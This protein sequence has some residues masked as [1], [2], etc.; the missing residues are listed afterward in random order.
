ML[1]LLYLLW[2]KGNSNTLR[3][4]WHRIWILLMNLLL[5]PLLVISLKFLGVSTFSYVTP[6]DSVAIHLL[7]HEWITSLF[8]VTS[9]L[10]CHHAMTVILISPRLHIKNC[11][12]QIC[13]QTLQQH[14][15]LVLAVL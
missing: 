7:T 15:I 2:F 5:T 11:F 4:I 8:I 12:F 9:Y 10:L 13:L 6:L 14:F 3:L 1:R